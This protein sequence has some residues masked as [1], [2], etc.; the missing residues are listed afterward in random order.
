MKRVISILFVVIYCSNTF[1]QPISLH[2]ENKHYFLYKGKPKVLVTSAEHYGAVLNKDFDYRKYLQTLHDEGMDYTRIFAGTY[3]E[4]AAYFDGAS[5][6]LAPATGSYL[7]PWERIGESGLFEGERKVDLSR[8]NNEFFDRLKDFV[9]L[10]NDLN[11]FVEVTLFSSTF[12]DICWERHPFNP[13]NNINGIPHDL[14][15]KK[16]NTLENGNL[17]GFQK[18]LVEKIVTELNGFDNIFYEIQNEPWYDDPVKAMRTLRTRDPQGD[19]SFKWARVA[20]DASLE[21]Q[22]EIAATIVK[23]EEK[24]SKKHLIAQNYTNFQ[25]SLKEVDPNI[26]ILNF[27][28]AWPESVWMNYAWN[29]PVSFDESGTAGSSDTTYLRQAWQFMMGGGAVFNNLDF[30]FYVGKE[31]GTGVKAGSLGGSTILR[32][33]LTYLRAFIE[34]LEFVKMQPDFNV[35]KHSPG[36]QWQA[37]SEPGKQYAI[38][39]TGTMTD[40]VKLNI[41]KG[42]YNYEFVSPFTGGTLKDGFFTSNRE[43]VVKLEFPQFDHLVALRIV[44]SAR[45]GSKIHVPK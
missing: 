13:G 9:L 21:W 7:T 45:S 26:S 33:Q 19:D 24:F 38:V 35:V 28:Y 11:I 29:L 37:I 39:F 27:H 17:L 23:T 1:S 43:G 14:N 25:Y 5:N 20:T 41:P 34:S 2:P 42:K 4:V 3:V 36:V 22:R 8:W 31:D 16:S 6:P 30:S 18:S 40:W 15:R 32:K 10:A 44:K 12:Q